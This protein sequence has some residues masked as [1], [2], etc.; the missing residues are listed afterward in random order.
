MCPAGV[1]ATLFSFAV[2]RLDVD[3]LRHGHRLDAFSKV[4]LDYHDIPKASP[5]KSESKSGENEER[6]NFRCTIKK[7]F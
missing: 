7:N 1:D 5:T 2:I 6:A 3:T 4:W